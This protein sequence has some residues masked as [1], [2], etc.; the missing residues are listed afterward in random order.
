[1]NE[2]DD[3]ISDRPDTVGGKS[4]LVAEY[5]ETRTLDEEGWCGALDIGTHLKGDLKST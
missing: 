5:E 1:M 4:G 2:G 3:N